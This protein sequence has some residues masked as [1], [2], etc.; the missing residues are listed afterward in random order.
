[1]GAEILFLIVLVFSI[2]V[3]SADYSIDISVDKQEA[4]SIGENLTFTVRLLEDGSQISKQV[5]VSLSD[6][7]SRK[8]IEKTVT[9]NQENSVLIGDDFPSGLWEIE[10][11]YKEKPVKRIFSIKEHTDV[12]F[13]LQEDKLIIRNNGNTRYKK[14]V[15]IIID[16][17]IDT[18]FLDIKVGEEKE[19]RL[20]APSGVYNIEVYVDGGNKLTRKDIYLTTTGNVVGALDEDLIDGSPLGGVRD[21]NVEDKFFSAG[22]FPIAF[23]FVGAIFALGLLLLVEKFLKGRAGE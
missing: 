16:D 9:T 2:S 12:D 18:H 4:Y 6:A 14:T 15:Q 19:L 1:M 13:I 3:V 23:I 10:T 7:L 11:S 8:K 20:V 17:N 22:R 5:T 21:S